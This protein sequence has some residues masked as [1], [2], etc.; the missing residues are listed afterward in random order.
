MIINFKTDKITLKFIHKK[1]KFLENYKNGHQ[2]KLLDIGSNHGHFTEL[3]KEY[4]YDAYGIDPYKPNI[5]K[6][7][8]EGKAKYIVGSGEKLPFPDNYFDLIVMFD[9]LEH[10][11][12]RDA[13]LKEINRVLKDAGEAIISIPNTWSW[14]HIR[15]FFI[16]LIRGMKPYKNIHFQQSYFAWERLI[17]NFLNIEWHQPAYYAEPILIC[18]KR[19]KQKEDNTNDGDEEL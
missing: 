11:I 6:C 1:T 3:M 2:K 8:R 17:S 14:F 10:I 15:K 5:L 13:C 4:G 18:T 19:D 9:T 12:S 16:Y 7:Q